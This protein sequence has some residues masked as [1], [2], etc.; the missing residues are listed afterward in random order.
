M[1]NNYEIASRLRNEPKEL[2]TATLFTCIGA[3]ALTTYKGLAF[4]VQCD[5]QDIDFMLEKI[6]SISTG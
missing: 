2:G 1:W 3:Q 4:T 5:R 6:G